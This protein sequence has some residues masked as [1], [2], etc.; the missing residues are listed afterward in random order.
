MIRIAIADDHPLISEG[1]K[2]LLARQ[3]DFALAGEASS[4][5]ELTTLLAATGCDVLV[6]DISLPDRNGLEV[7]PELRKRYPHVAVLVLS[8][9]PEDRFALKALRSGAAGYL[10]KSSA[11]AEL[12]KAVRKVA[13]GGRYISDALAE[14]FALNS[15]AGGQGPA[16]EALSAREFQV[17]LLLAQGIIVKEA[18]ARL[19]LSVN[20]VHTYRRRIL[21]KLSLQSNTHLAL[22]AMRHE[23]ID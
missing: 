18:A 2:K 17:F 5:S 15:V 10:S 21:E 9:H 8:M 1:F 4:S 22:Y 7:L 11:A 14:I 19:G 12:I 20:T 3:P 23:L 13:S 6:L 16:H